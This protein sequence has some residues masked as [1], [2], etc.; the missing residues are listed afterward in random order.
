VEDGEKELIL[1][2]DGW[3]TGVIADERIAKDRMRMGDWVRM[4]NESH[5]FGWE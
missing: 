4:E 1:L 3:A 5:G 2:G